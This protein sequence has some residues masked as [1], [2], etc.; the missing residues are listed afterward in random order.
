MPDF[1]FVLFR[2]V[3][4]IDASCG[5]DRKLSGARL[6]DEALE[7]FGKWQTDQYVPPE[8]K[9]GVVPRN[10]YGNVDLFKECMLPKGTVHMKREHE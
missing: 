1:R 6:K 7:V 3:S 8:A 4:L 9:N 5:I 2:F 10:E